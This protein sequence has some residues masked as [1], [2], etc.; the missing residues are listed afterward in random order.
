MKTPLC[1]LLDF[2]EELAGVD[3]WLARGGGGLAHRPGPFGDEP[4]Q[5]GA[6]FLRGARM[7]EQPFEGKRRGT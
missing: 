3:A 1:V 4:S 5:E 2:P 6:P 7:R